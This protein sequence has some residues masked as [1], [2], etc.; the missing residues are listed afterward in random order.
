MHSQLQKLGTRVL[1]PQPSSPLPKFPLLKY[2][3]AKAGPAGFL[4]ACPLSGQGYN[5]ITDNAGETH[6]PSGL[7]TLRDTVPNNAN[8][9]KLSLASPST[10]PEN[11]V[12]VGAS[13]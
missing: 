13:C 6:S 1:A 4:L 12:E 10:L 8:E 5:I 7:L 3:L 11:V 2:Q 9:T